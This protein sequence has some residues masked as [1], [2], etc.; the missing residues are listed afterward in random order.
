LA[1]KSLNIPP[2]SRLNQ[3]S[4]EN[5]DGIP[6]EGTTTAYSQLEMAEPRLDAHHTFTTRSS[7]KQP[8]DG[9]CNHH[10]SPKEFTP[11]LLP[12]DQ[13]TRSKNDVQ[14]E[15]NYRGASINQMSKD[16][17][18]LQTS[19]WKDPGCENYT[20]SGVHHSCQG[21]PEHHSIQHFSAGENHHAG[22]SGNCNGGY[23]V[24]STEPDKMYPGRIMAN[25]HLRSERTSIC[26][27][28]NSKDN[29]DL[30]SPRSY[31]DSCKWL[32]PLILD[33]VDT[34]DMEKR[35]CTEQPHEL[36][37][38]TLGYKHFRLSPTLPRS[39][40]IQ[41][42]ASMIQSKLDLNK[43][44]VMTNHDSGNS[45]HSE[46][47]L[48][49]STDRSG[50]TKPPQ[51]DI[52]N[53]TVRRNPYLNVHNS[54]F[55]AENSIDQR[56]LGGM[57]IHYYPAS[58]SQWKGNQN[59]VT[60]SVMQKERNPFNRSGSSKFPRSHSDEPITS[61]VPEFNQPFEIGEIWKKVILAR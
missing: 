41:R 2:K 22:T 58:T 10:V 45:L 46:K 11:A 31:M 32:Q 30:G 19:V 25:G 36:S 38:T 40:T 17:G 18:T 59:N 9:N 52:S 3:W 42:S 23:Y 21:A 13:H 4:V 12:S 5:K 14:F 7:I 60:S 27:P 20:Q 54:A 33:S 15:T 57:Q 44:H 24:S 1:N 48:Q 35:I 47:L 51:C 53:A 55:T 26:S 16:Y 61:T 49:G 39:Q 28:V 6:K 34:F 37:S 29:K 8:T 56:G 50:L 43:P